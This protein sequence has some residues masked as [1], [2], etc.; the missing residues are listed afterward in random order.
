[1]RSAFDRGLQRVTLGVKHRIGPQVGIELE[2][3]H[4]G[5]HGDAYPYW[6]GAVDHSLRERGMELISIPLKPIQVVPA[7]R[8]VKIMPGFKPSIASER[9]GLHIHLNASDLTLRQLWCVM[10][11]YALVEP[12]VFKTFAP[13]REDNHFCVPLWKDGRQVRQLYE[14][15]Q[16]LR[17]NIAKALHVLKGCKYS[18]MNTATLGKFGTL[19]FR[20]HPG[21]KS[22]LEV[23][24]WAKFII[25]L[26]EEALKFGD[27]LDI[28]DLYEGQGVRALLDRVRLDEVEVDPFAKEDAVDAATMMSGYVPAKWQEIDWEMA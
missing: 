25:S 27:A 14:D 5:G 17:R 8:T 23:A 26:R 12:Y 16:G 7:L 10:A 19:E 13:T 4:F 21:T 1:M 3:E 20:Q 2:Y 18:A 11:F 15:V 24:Q 9:C 6:R 28:V 22:L